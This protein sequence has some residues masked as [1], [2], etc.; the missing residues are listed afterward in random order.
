[1]TKNEVC[2]SIIKLRILLILHFNTIIISFSPQ[3]T[4][5]S[6]DGVQGAEYTIDPIIIIVPSVVGGSMLICVVPM[7]L[8]I[9]CVCMLVLQEE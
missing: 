5:G 9:C 8:I 6:R 4:V 2:I 3:V 7:I 1:M